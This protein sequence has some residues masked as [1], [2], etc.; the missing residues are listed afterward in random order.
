MTSRI[1]RVGGMSCGGCAAAVTRAI[2]RTDPAAKVAVDL[3]G[4][5]VTVSGPTS[6]AAVAAAIAAAGFT[7]EGV[8]ADEG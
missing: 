2:T 7:Y 6:E 5:K 8:S 4:G 1:Y 3:A